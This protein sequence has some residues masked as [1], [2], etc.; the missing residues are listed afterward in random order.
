MPVDFQFKQ[1]YTMDDLL[2]IMEIL[3]SDEGCPWDREQTHSSIRHNFLEET[4]EVLEAIDTRNSGLLQE[5]L[6]D[7]LLQVVFHARMEQEAG[8]FGFTEVTDGICKKLIERHPH[9]FADTVASTSE[10]VLSNW[11]DIKR[12]TK[13]QAS[14][15]EAMNS[16]PKVFPA[17]MKS[18][19][20]QAKASK[21]GMDWQDA[22]G[23]F[24]KLEEESAEL[25]RALAD[26][27]PE[28]VLAELGDLLFSAVNIAR[29]CGCEAETA[30]SLATDRFVKRFT[31][32]ENR[33]SELS[34]DMKTLPP[35]E[36]DK[37]WELAKAQERQ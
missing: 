12:R 22:E 14:Q 18:Q 3:R 23:A 33:C 10:Q 19:K 9:I 17:L 36:L 7:V 24:K 6:G 21:A 1:K 30:L 27:N 28:Q 16:V 5:E 8:T 34:L 29:F 2:R 31:F 15:S 11:D 20:I 25:K 32:A 4:Y 26:G 35:E 13:G 37:L